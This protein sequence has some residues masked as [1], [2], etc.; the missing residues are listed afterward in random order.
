MIRCWLPVLLA[1]SLALVVG[2]PTALAQGPDPSSNK[3]AGKHFRRGVA[4][5]NETDYRGALAEFRRAYEIAPNAA[6]LYNIGEAYYQLQN[7]AAAMTVF[8]RYMVEAGTTAPH[9]R[10]VEQTLEILHSRVGK[11]RVTTNVPGCEVTVDD[12]LVGKA[13]FEF[14]VVVS[15][16]R[17]K[18]TAMLPGRVPDTRFVEV[19]AGDTVDL[20]LSLGA[21][22]GAAG[23]RSG[24][25]D[26]VTGGWVATGV[27]AAATIGA[28]IWAFSA[29]RQLQDERKK[30]PTSRD[31][32]DRR[33]SHAS[34]ISILADV[35]GAAT[36]I[37]GAITLRFTL[38]RSKSQGVHVA[39]V[40]YGIELAG[41]FH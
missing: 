11:I 29:S 24:G 16:G 20:T 30:F 13:P 31:E 40:P 34:N 15:V 18:I 35:L 6:V 14:P 33:A 22:G 37:T 28:S 1:I 25:F 8:E 4:L 38:T 32:L 3:E 19:A 12:E 39:V 27:L 10:E 7:Y 17:R 2:T 26:L 5:Y 36:V 21:P 9:H 23:G 41:S